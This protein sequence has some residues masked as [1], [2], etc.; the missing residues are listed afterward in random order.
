M[1]ELHAL[2]G[3]ARKSLHGVS[4]GGLADAGGFDPGVGDS[5][6]VADEVPR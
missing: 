6:E 3:P 2:D 1:L 4:G 5:S